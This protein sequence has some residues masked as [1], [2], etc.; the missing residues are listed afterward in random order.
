MNTAR[1]NV[2]QRLVRQ[3][4]TVHP[5][6]AAQVLRIAGKPDLLAIRRAWHATL[7][8][9]ELGP[10]RVQG[11]DFHF[12]AVNGNAS[13]FLVPVVPAGVSLEQHISEEMNHRFEDSEEL[14]LRPFVLQEGDGESFHFGIVYQH[15][16]ADSAAIRLL[17][18]EW[19]VRVYD[20]ESATDAALVLPRGGYWEN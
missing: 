9:L 7:S 1:L 11:L 15:W 5:Y 4:D 20:P 17:L 10:V 13:K 6:N 2:F 8:T 19:F 12:E 14:P 16:I 18:R 3:W